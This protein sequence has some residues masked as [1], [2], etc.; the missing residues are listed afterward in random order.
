MSTHFWFLGM[1]QTRV[2]LSRPN[3]IG[4]ALRGV[5]G[6]AERHGGANR[7]IVTLT[8]DYINHADFF[9]FPGPLV[10]TKDRKECRMREFAMQHNPAKKVLLKRVLSHA[11]TTCNLPL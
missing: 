6:P 1:V 3:S 11:D 5:P 10:P 7:W 2:T 4:N 8:V 9:L